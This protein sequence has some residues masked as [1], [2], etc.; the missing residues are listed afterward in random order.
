MKINKQQLLADFL[1]FLESFEVEGYGR[2]A[3]QLQ[4]GTNYEGWIMAIKD[5]TLTWL[6]SGPLAQKEPIIVDLEQIDETSLYYFDS[7]SYQWLK[8]TQNQ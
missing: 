7:A 4:D 2:C 1:N 3:F 6:S 5:E 8:F